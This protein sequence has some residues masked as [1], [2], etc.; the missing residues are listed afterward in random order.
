MITVTVAAAFPGLQEVME[1]E[2]AEGAT[3]ADALERS[4]LQERHPGIDFNASPVGIWSRVCGRDTVL[5]HGDRVELYRPL[6][7]DPKEM[8]RRRARAKP[9]R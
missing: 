3:V 8:R 4:G 2:L 7:A 6:K 9:P 5:R 1:V